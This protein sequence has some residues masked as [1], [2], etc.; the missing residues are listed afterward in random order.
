[1]TTD[2]GAELKRAPWRDL[3]LLVASA[4]IVLDRIDRG[5]VGDSGDWRVWARWATVALWG[6]VAVV[7]ARRLWSQNRA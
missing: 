3:L 2:T 4:V 6:S 7:A 1:M 5:L